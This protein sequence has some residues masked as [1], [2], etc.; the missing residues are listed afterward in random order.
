MPGSHCFL[1]KQRKEQHEKESS[2]F[3]MLGKYFKTKKP[4]GFYS[5]TRTQNGIKIS[6]INYALECGLYRNFFFGPDEIF[7]HVLWSNDDSRHLCGTFDAQVFSRLCTFIYLF[8]QQK[9]V[10]V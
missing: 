5:I 7:I 3:S 6:L 1:W 9:F 4:A 8:I 10:R 2:D